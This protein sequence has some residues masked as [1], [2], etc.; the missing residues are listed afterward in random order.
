MLSS[1][2][3]SEDT[4]LLPLDIC[5]SF[6]PPIIAKPIRRIPKNNLTYKN[7]LNFLF[8]GLPQLGHVL[9]VLL[10]VAP[11]SLQRSPFSMGHPQLGQ[12]EALSETSCPHSEHFIKAI[13]LLLIYNYS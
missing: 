4:G 8:S 2:T 13:S 5:N 3:L 11:H 6:I 9:S 10:M 1:S 7:K 12:V